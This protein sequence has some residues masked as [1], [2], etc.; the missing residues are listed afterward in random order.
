MAHPFGNLGN[1]K[2]KVAIAAVA[3][4]ALGAWTLWK[5]SSGKKKW[6][7]ASA[8]PRPQIYKTDPGTRVRRR[9]GYN[10][11]PLPFPNGWVFVAPSDA[12]PTAKVLPIEVCGKNLVAFRANDGTVGV[13]DAFCPHMGTHLGYGGFVKDQCIVCPYHEWE[14]DTAGKLQK[15]P[16]A[17]NQGQSDCSRDRNHIHS[18]TVKEWRGMVFAWI[19]ADDAEPWN[20]MDC[21]GIVDSKNMVSLGRII[22]ED[23]NMHPMEPSHNSCDWYHFNTVHSLLGQHWMSRFKFIHIEQ[24]I[25]PA[26]SHASNSLD[27]D[28]KPMDKKEVLLIDEEV[29]SMTL[30]NGLIRVPAS[31]IQNVSKTQVEFS[32]ALVVMFKVQVPYVGM[33]CVVMPLTPTAPF[34]THVE[35]WTFATPGFLS[36]ITGKVLTWGVQYT[37]NQDREV[38]ENRTHFMPRNY[39]KGDY[40]WQKYDQWLKCFYSE[41]SIGWDSSAYSW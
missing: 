19:H 2:V 35:W 6:P 29:L 36:Y 8:S 38:W 7:L 20:L 11:F 4:T 3:T 33:V 34:V 28:G 31:F 17:P 40:N 26:R 15:V 10:V 12:I 22:A 25:K 39:V 16:Y 1:D 21:L 18:Y 41:R 14:F 23:F 13:L 5:L 37:V 24:T 32:G 27:D 30:F 9:E